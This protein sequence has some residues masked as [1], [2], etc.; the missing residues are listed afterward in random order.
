ME[1]DNIRWKRNKIS[2]ISIILFSPLCF[3]FLPFVYT[4]FNK[5][6]LVDFI[7]SWVNTI[8]I[9]IILILII[10]FGI[11]SSSPLKYFIS[12]EEIIL[13]N[14]LKSKSYY[15]SEISKVKCKDYWLELIFNNNKKEGFII[16]KDVNIMIYNTFRKYQKLNS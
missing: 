14:I 13:K 12:D 15:F 3:A 11:T 6:L 10:Y 7:S 4:Y 8:F 2:Y 16:D 1:D 9:G 5:I